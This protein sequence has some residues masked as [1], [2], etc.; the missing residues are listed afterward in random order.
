MN[1][2]LTEEGLKGCLK[3][4]PPPRSI[5]KG[6]V[7]GA[8]QVE[9]HS[10]GEA[11]RQQAG[12]V[13]PTHQVHGGS[14]GKQCGRTGGVVVYRHCC[15]P[16]PKTGIV[17]V[18]W[19]KLP[20]RQAVAATQRVVHPTSTTQHR[21]VCLLGEERSKSKSFR[22]SLQAAWECHCS[23][24]A[25]ITRRGTPPKNSHLNEL[26]KQH[27]PLRA[28]CGYVCE[29]VL[30]LPPTHEIIYSTSVCIWYR[31]AESCFMCVHGGRKLRQA[32][33]ACVKGRQAEAFCVMAGIQGSVRY[34]GMV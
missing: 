33:T 14:A 17:R 32:C 22:S 24:S 19:W 13:R 20:A 18:W 31:Q 28:M 9:M 5:R 11:G 21:Q 26:S 29:K 12:M 34:A 27:Q 10:A 15:C 25:G 30:P 2:V 1:G 6:K 3:A 7:L 8:I 4:P 16:T 23:G